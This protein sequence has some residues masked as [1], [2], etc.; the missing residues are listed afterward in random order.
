LKVF[1]PLKALW[2]SELKSLRGLH[3]RANFYKCGDGLTVPHFVTWA[4]IAT[5][6]PDYHRP[7]FFADLL[8]V[9]E[10]G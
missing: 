8:F 1:I 6:K 3:A 7:E 4:P 10:N 9:P 5:E 2:K